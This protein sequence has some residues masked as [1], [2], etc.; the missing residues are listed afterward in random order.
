M[1]G[2][3]FA[4][5]VQKFFVLTSAIGFGFGIA[6][7]WVMPVVAKSFGKIL[8]GAFDGNT[9]KTLAFLGDNRVAIG[10]GIWVASTLICATAFRTLA[11]ALAKLR[12]FTVSNADAIAELCPE[13]PGS[14]GEIVKGVTHKIANGA[15]RPTL[16]DGR[17]QMLTRFRSAVSIVFLGTALSLMIQGWISG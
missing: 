17:W 2:T 3:R 8:S 5:I 10:F 14:I 1:K 7:L 6:N 12:P 15:F 4:G 13:W 16:I 9:V 11:D